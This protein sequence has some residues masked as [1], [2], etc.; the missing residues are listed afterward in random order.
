MLY[1]CLG[2][3]IARVMLRAMNLPKDFLSTPAR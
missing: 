1:D 2:R 3:Q